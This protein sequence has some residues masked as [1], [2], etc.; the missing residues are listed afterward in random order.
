MKRL[1]IF[2]ASGHGAVVADAAECCGWEV[3]FFDDD[4]KAVLP[5][6]GWKLLGSFKCLIERLS[7]FDGVIVAIGNNR[8]RLEKSAVIE[9]KGGKPVSI[10]HPT[11]SVSRYSVI[12][13]G[14]VVMAGASVNIG[15]HIGRCCIV[16]TG[17]TVDHDCV[18]AEGVHVSP[19]A[20]LAGGVSVGEATWIGIGASVKQSITIGRDCTVGAG[21]A[22][23]YDVEDSLIV[24]GVPAVQLR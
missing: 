4:N 16:N 19:G 21:A 12:K 22:V 24:G 9:A 6:C 8:I 7:E 3:A 13:S 23:I 11:A 18:L 15:A 5:V 10:I 17:A 2:G 20:N 14:S 1:A